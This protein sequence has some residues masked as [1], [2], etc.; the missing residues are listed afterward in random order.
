M[1]LAASSV[2]SCLIIVASFSAAN[3]RPSFRHSQRAGVVRRG[4]AHV[5]GRADHT[6]QERLIGEEE[7]A[8][9]LQWC[10]STS[11]PRYRTVQRTILRPTFLQYDRPSLLLLLALYVVSWGGERGDASSSSCGKSRNIN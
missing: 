7:D 3:P 8:A 5:R 1:G 10:V 11:Y 4:G 9:D 6:V 2:G